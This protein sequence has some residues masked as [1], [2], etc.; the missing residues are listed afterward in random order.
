[1]NVQQGMQQGNVYRP[2][3]LLTTLASIILRLSTVSLEVFLHHGF[4]ERHFRIVDLVLGL[5]S[6]SLAGYFIQ[7]FVPE[8]VIQVATFGHIVL[9]LGL[10]HLWLIQRRKKKGVIVHSRYWG[11]SLFIFYWLRIPHQTIQFLVEPLLCLVAGVLFITYTPYLLVGSWIVIGAISWGILCQIEIW[12]WNNRILDAIDQEIEARNFEAAVVERKSP[13]ETQ[14]F[15]VPVS[16]NFTKEQRTSLKDAFERLDPG[17]K[18]LMGESLEESREEDTK[19]R[20]EP[21]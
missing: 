20:E 8:S 19:N 1:M 21:L 13:R 7:V 2:L 14:G 16:P 6:L 17:L 11:D 18:E 12:K 4:G 9:A 3:A 15:F 5:L 10:I